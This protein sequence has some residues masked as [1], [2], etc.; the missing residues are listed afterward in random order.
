MRAVTDS[1]PSQMNQEKPEAIQNL[2]TLLKIVS[3]TDTYNFFDEKYNKCEI[4]YGDLKKQLAADII[5]FTNPFRERIMDIMANDE[6][7]H[8]VAS[9]GAEKAR[10][11]ASK[12]L[13]EVRKIIGFRK[14]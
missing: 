1:G 5:A 9:L 3:A 2:F 4:R 12:T 8:R 7:L 6:Y 11:S 10:E 13:S 14:F